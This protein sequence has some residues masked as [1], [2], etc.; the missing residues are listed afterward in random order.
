[1]GGWNP[2]VLRI[3]PLLAPSPLQTQPSSLLD[4]GLDEAQTLDDLE[5]VVVFSIG[6]GQGRSASGEARESDNGRHA[7]EAADLPGIQLAK[8]C[9]ILQIDPAIPSVAADTLR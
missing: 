8:V 6:G 5:Q 2:G 3:E 1:M 4:F 9:G 7:A